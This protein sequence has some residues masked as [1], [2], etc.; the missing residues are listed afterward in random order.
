MF[1]ALASYIAVAFSAPLNAKRR[2]G[3]S[4]KTTNCQIAK[5]RYRP[6]Y[7]KGSIG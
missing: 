4:K 7:K 5:R 3:R 2:V 1:I 6:T